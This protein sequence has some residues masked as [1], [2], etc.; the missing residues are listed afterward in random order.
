MKCSG[1]VVCGV[2]V[3]GSLLLANPAALAQHAPHSGGTRAVAPAGGGGHAQAVPRAS[4]PSGPVHAQAVPRGG[5]PV[6]G[7][8]VVGT[9]VPRGSVPG[10]HPPYNHYPYHP[11]YPYYGYP[12]YGWG[13]PSYGYGYGWGWGIGLS[14]YYSP[15]WWGF[16]SPWWNGYAPYG[17]YGYPY[18]GYGPYGSYDPNA[19][20]SASQPAESP[21]GQIELKVKPKEAQ[22]YVDGYFVG[23]VGD[24]EGWGKRLTV[25]AAPEPGQTHKIEFRYPGYET[26]S[27]DVSTTPGQS[28]TYRGELKKAA[29]EQPKR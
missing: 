5:R 11:Y 2:F 9:A 25:K 17:W 4:R 22:V 18:W 8:P 20:G 10:Y 19:G 28:I 21:T 12:Y 3:A 29:T 26:L 13:Y 27:F 16:G 15:Y 1:I 24:F 23:S 6:G 14:F 7:R